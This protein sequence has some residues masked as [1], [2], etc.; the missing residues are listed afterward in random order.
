MAHD[1]WACQEGRRRKHSK[2]E[3]VTA[4]SKESG[5]AK[6]DWL[7]VTTCAHDYDQRIVLSPFVR[8]EKLRLPIVG[9]DR[10]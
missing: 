8:A 9:P 3:C 7:C 5:S 4:V 2:S 10:W 1:L 6:L